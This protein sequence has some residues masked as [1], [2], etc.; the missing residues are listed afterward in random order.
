MTKN[1]AI[2]LNDFS[3]VKSLY[4]NMDDAS[5]KLTNRMRFLDKI[6]FR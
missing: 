4:L 3:L 1:K 2:F 6:V 5:L